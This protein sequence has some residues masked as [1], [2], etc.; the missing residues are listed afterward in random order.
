MGPLS[1]GHGVGH[2]FLIFSVSS[3]RVSYLITVVSGLLLDVI[4]CWLQTALNHN[5]LFDQLEIVIL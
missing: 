3:A 5:I 2:D 1:L 4:Q